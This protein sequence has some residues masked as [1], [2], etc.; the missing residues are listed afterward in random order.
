M[1]TRLLRRESLG[2]SIGSLCFAVGVVSGYVDLVGARGANVTLFV[3][4]LFFTGA[5]FAQLRLNGR[6]R[7]D[8][9]AQRTVRQDWWSA[10]VQFVG[11]LC[12]NVST[13]LA[14]VARVGDEQT[15]RDAWSPDAVGSTCFLISGVLAVAATTYRQGLWGPATRSWWNAWLNMAGCVAFGAAAAGAYVVPW[16][17]QVLDIRADSVGTFVGAVCFLAAALLV[18]PGRRRAVASGADPV[19]ASGRVAPVDDAAP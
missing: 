10:A 13:V 11:T 9:W 17:G 2:F 12:F 1:R 16:S 6:W 18:W 19:S 14:V 15:L 5:A 4:S 3:G 8:A 7:G